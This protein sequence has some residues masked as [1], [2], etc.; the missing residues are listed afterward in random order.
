MEFQ[1]IPGLRHFSFWPER[2]RSRYFNSKSKI[3]NQKFSMNPP[4][5]LFTDIAVLSRVNR[6]LLTRFLE[7]VR[8]SLP[9]PAAA[10]LA[11][12]LHDF[13]AF[14][15]AWAALFAAPGA[16]PEAV[17][18]ALHAIEQL[19][20]PGNR[21]QLEATISQVP[22]NYINPDASPLNQALHLWMIAIAMPDVV[23]FP[24]P[25]APELRPAPPA[26]QPK[27]ETQNPITELPPAAETA[28]PDAAVTDPSKIQNQNID[29]A[30]VP[31][32]EERAEV[33]AI[34]SEPA[35]TPA[36]DESKIENQ[37][38]KTET[39]D[40]T[41]HRLALLALPEYD[42]ARRAEAKRLGLR[43]ATLDR[44]VERCRCLQYDAQANAVLLRDLDPWPEPI[45]DAPALFDEVDQR[46]VLQLFTPA[47]APVVFAMWIPHAHAFT[48]FHLSP[49]LNLFSIE[50]GCGKTTG[51]DIMTPMLP[52]ALRAE[53][54]KPAV[55]Y[56]VVHRGQPTLCM[57][58]VD[59]YLH[60]YSELR[61]LLNAGHKSDS[62]A[63]RCGAGRYDVNAYKTF[64]PTVLAGIGHLPP[65]LRDR[66]IVI[67]L[68]KAQ[69]G[70]VQ[71]R[72]NPDKAEIERTLG[73]KIARWAKDNYAAIAAFDDPPLPAIASNRLA[74]NWRPLFTIAHIIG[75]H[76]PERLTEAFYALNP[77]RHH[78]STPSHQLPSPA[79]NPQVANSPNHQHSNLDSFSEGGLAPD[80]QLLIASLRS[81]F[82]QS[83]ADRM[84]A[85]DLVAQLNSLPDHPWSSP[86]NGKPM[87]ER[88]LA[89]RLRPLGIQSRTLWIAGTAAKGYLR[90]DFPSA[91]DQAPAQPGRDGEEKAEG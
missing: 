58:E 82:A 31:V 9:A 19:S 49:R 62:Q 61:A 36:S 42:R 24:L 63:L 10:L 13:E 44:E 71:L 67:P 40:D 20:L 56:R 1:P 86:V 37:N 57:D 54:L 50:H 14:C 29:S 6:S 21:A 66:S 33:S 77:T 70:Q 43:L 46:F 8:G 68:V 83:G 76:W 25:P 59:C 65:T 4:L 12:P 53:S 30:P 80:P 51:L 3:K 32:S 5:K 28:T 69:P 91:S 84:F 15:A 22:P 2:Q 17:I 79:N 11:A 39:E 48:A 89:C 47:G 27:G 55:V 64:C 41:F 45:L 73:R 38:P 72:F 60:L 23:H 90:T 88:S 85:R 16:L 75:G 35:A 52:R 74:D 26:D 81:I 7:D 78:I 87:T 34:S 18:R